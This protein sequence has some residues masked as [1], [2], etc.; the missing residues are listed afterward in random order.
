MSV[1]YPFARLLAAML[2]GA[3]P[4]AV[5]AAT[6][7]VETPARAIILHPLKILK[8]DDMDFGSVIVTTA[9]TIIL[10][11]V[12]SAVTATGGVVPVSGSPHPARFVGAASGN[13]VVN[14]KIPKQPVTLTRLTGTEAMRLR[15]FTLDSADKRTIARSQSFVFKVG[16]TVDVGANQVEGTYV[17]TFNVIVQY[18]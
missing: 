7:P 12:T 4:A 17:G 5:H 16:G 2:L 9:G 6:P 18:P 15:N 13:S 10:N 3:L 1:T 11:P 14:I 8:L